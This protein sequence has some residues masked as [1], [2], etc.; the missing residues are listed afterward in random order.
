MAP[1]FVGG[2]SRARTAPNRIGTAKDQP[3]TPRP[4]LSW[5][6]EGRTS[7]R[8]TMAPALSVGGLP[9]LA[10]FSSP[11]P[12]ATIGSPRART[13]P[14]G[15]AGHGNPSQD[16]SCSA[17]VRRMTVVPTSGFSNAEPKAA[18]RSA[19][20]PRAKRHHSPSASESQRRT[21]RP[22]P[23]ARTAT[24]EPSVFQRSSEFPTPNQGQ[25]VTFSWSAE[26]AP[27]TLRSRP[28]QTASPVRSAMPPGGATRHDR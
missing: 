14:E 21:E 26:S 13:G 16:D 20:Q 7:G 11:A 24:V 4:A 19:A 1:R 28:S 22:M 8:S 25:T 10:W 15:R 9:G 17:E 12:R 5:G 23:T 3:P 18:A 27:A 2:R 6:Q